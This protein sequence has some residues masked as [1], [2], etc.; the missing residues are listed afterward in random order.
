MPR[1]AATQGDAGA[2]NG[3][4]ASHWFLGSHTWLASMENDPELAARGMTVA[5]EIEETGSGARNDRPGLQRRT[6]AR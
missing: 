6:T 2:K 5:L 1:V 3:T 4:V